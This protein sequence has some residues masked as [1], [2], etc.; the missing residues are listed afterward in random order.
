MPMGTCRA[1]LR[2]LCVC[3]SPVRCAS[4]SS[5]AKLNFW[6]VGELAKLPRVTFPLSSDAFDNELIV[7]T[8]KEI[9]EGK[10]V[11]IPVY[12]FVSH[13][14]SNSRSCLAVPL[15]TPCGAAH[16]L[17]SP[18]RPPLHLHPL[19]GTP[20]AN[21]KFQ[22]ELLQTVWLEDPGQTQARSESLESCAAMQLH[23]AT[24]RDQWRGEGYG[25]PFS[26]PHP[27]F[28]SS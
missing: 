6:W 7:K 12:D 8:L 21:Q 1:F 13:S 20:C 10:T 25:P 26:S 14:R 23:A 24:C 11:Q 4:G 15:L 27:H 5:Q 16:S 2:N 3:L 22:C 19:L 9:T 18:N 17:A 28:L